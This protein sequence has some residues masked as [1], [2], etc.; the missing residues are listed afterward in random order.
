[1]TSPQDRPD[2]QLLLQEH[3]NRWRDIF[4]LRGH[5]GAGIKWAVSSFTLLV[6]FLAAPV[7]FPAMDIKLPF[8][9]AHDS[10]GDVPLGYSLLGILVCALGSLLVW[11][12]SRKYCQAWREI[13]LS[14]KAIYAIR[15]ILLSGSPSVDALPMQIKNGLLYGQHYP[16]LTRGD[17]AATR[18]MAVALFM[19][20]MLLLYFL[21]VFCREFFNNETYETYEAYEVIGGYLA[22]SVLCLV[23][24]MY[25]PFV[26]AMDIMML[27]A[28]T[29]TG[30]KNWI[31]DRDQPPKYPGILKHE[32]NRMQCYQVVLAGACVALALAALGIHWGN[33]GK[34]M[35]NWPWVALWLEPR[36][37]GAAL[38]VWVILAIA[39]VLTWGRRLRKQ[40]QRIRVAR[41][42]RPKKHP[43]KGRARKRP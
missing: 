25:G 30:G 9:G 40:C 21:P 2:I 15:G 5:M 13:V 26:Q 1:M 34:R 38:G 3:E 8:R 22:L 16:Q 41:G 17:R 23:A 37:I 4:D 6:A 7:L 12:A 18:F 33:C 27:E 28:E 11:V 32:T 39:N 36:G 14:Y 20:P 10:L 19:C 29:A 35:D 24:R 43:R 31:L 42:A